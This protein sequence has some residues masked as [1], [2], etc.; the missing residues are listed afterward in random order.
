MLV[1]ADRRNDMKYGARQRRWDQ[2]GMDYTKT[3][4]LPKFTRM[5]YNFNG[6]NRSDFHEAARGL[7]RSNFCRREYLPRQGVRSRHAY[8]GVG[9]A[10]QSGGRGIGR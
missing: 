4:D 5:W 2:R 8:D 7:A 9:G 6:E 3:V 1:D 10:R